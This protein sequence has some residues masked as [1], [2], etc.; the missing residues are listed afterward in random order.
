MQIVNKGVSGEH[1]SVM[2]TRLA[3]LLAERRYDWVIILGGTNDLAYD[4]DTKKLAETLIKLHSMCHEAGARTVALT[5]PECSYEAV[6]GSD[7]D[8]IHV[9]NL[10]RVRRERSTLKI[11]KMLTI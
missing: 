1:A 9:I 4:V 7:H 3:A 8:L 10:Y 2:G 11:E 5:I 6:S